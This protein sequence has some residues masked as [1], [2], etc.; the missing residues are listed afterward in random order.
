MF[1]YD[2]ELIPP[3]LDLTLMKYF[4]QFNSRLSGC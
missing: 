3:Y 2:E 1:L 4:S